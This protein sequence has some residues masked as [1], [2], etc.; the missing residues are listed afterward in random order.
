MSRRYKQHI[1]Q[2]LRK[3]PK[4]SLS[5]YHKE[6]KK[7][8]P[9]SLSVLLIIPRGGDNVQVTL[10]GY[11]HTSGTRTPRVTQVGYSAK[12]TLL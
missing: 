8:G 6:D 9:E 11:K 5:N 2:L 12:S 4:Y 7:K 1:S 10:E 3:P